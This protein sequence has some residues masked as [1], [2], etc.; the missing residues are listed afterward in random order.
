MDCKDVQAEAY[1]GTVVMMKFKF[2]CIAIQNRLT[3]HN[4]ESEYIYSFVPELMFGIS[5][6]RITGDLSFHSQQ[7]GV[8]IIGQNYDVCLSEVRGDDSQ[9]IA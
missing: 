6:E 1:P 7:S 4:N 5:R 8:F 2:R 9:D 3:G